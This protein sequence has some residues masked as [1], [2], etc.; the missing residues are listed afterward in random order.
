MAL[1]EFTKQIAQQAILSATTEKPAPPAPAPQTENL[2]SAVLGQ[3]HAMQKALKD[4][5]ELAV[6]CNAGADRIRVM[7]IFAPSRQLLVV[8]G[9][10]PE[11]NVTRIIAA[12]ESL[13]LV[14]KVIKVAAGAKPAR[15]AL[16]TP[17]PKDST[18]G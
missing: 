17:K 14:C 16:V 13:Q 10:D 8:S 3:I 7:E 2:T 18:A 11:R 4:D 6:Y 9:T 5:E 12:V 1:G 15:V